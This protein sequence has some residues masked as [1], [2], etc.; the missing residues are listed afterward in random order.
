MELE[1]LERQLADEALY[2]EPARRAELTRLVRSQAA[3]RERLTVLEDEWLQFS[4]ALEQARNTA[5]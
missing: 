2:S 1:L 5:R 3:A 4:A